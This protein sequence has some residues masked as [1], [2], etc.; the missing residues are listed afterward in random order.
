MPEKPGTTER[1]GKSRSISIPVKPAVLIWARESMGRTVKEAAAILGESEE[2]VLQWE[3]GQ[4]QPTLHQVK[5]LARFYKRPLAAFFLPGPPQE[6]SLPHDFRTLPDENEIPLSPKTRLAMRQ[7]RRLQ[8]IASELKEDDEG[9]FHARIGRALLS[10]D[11]EALACNVR[12]SLGI[13]LDEQ[14]SWEKDT[15]AMDRWK[16]SVESQGILVFQMSMPLEETRAFSF[17]DGGLPVIVINTR[18]ALRARIFS[19]FHELGHILLNE[20]GICDPSKLGGEESSKKDKSIEAFCNFFAGAILIPRESLLSHR[21]VV[22]KT[23][24]YK[25]P[26]R[27]LGTISNDFKVSKEVILRRLLI[28]GLT[29]RE[30][31][32]LKHNEWMKKERKPDS[33]KG[34]GIKRDIPKECLQ[35]NGTPL[36]SLVL[37]SYRND[38]ITTSDVADYL[39]IRVKHIPRIERLLEA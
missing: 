29:S 27:T 3:A 30:F 31:Y 16:K 14:L 22:G 9:D 34:K 18:D 38:R 33:A 23:P 7:A 5:A 26:E 17:T 13:S 20:G 8:S 12:E 24:S 28:A 4:Q 21:L 35:R 1:E 39:G 36:T 2:L 10:D 32:S 15:S 11:P 19:L 6:L 37:D 25:W